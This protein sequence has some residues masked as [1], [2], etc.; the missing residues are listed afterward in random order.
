[1]SSL[2]IFATQSGN[3]PLSELDD[4]FAEVSQRVNTANYV[5]AGNQSNITNVGTLNSLSVFGNVVAGNVSTTRNISAGN[6]RTTG[7]ISAAGN[8][9]GNYLFG[10][11]GYLSNVTVS[12]NVAVT[13][14]ANGVSV[15]SIAGSGGAATVQIAG[16]ANVAVF[17]S[18]GVSVNGQISA[19]GNVDAANIFLSG[20]QVAVGN[21]TGG[22]LNATT[23]MS[24]NGNAT[25]G[26]VVV[27][28]Q[29][30]AA[31]NV[32]GANISTT[33]TVNATGNVRGANI[34]TDGVV[35]AVGNV[36]GANIITTGTV[37]AD[38]NVRGA[39]ISTDGVVTA[40]GNVRGANI[41]ANGT[42]SA[43]GNISGN[44]NILLP[45]GFLITPGGTIGNN[46]R[47]GGFLSAVGTATLGN[48]NTGGVIS[49]TGNIIADAG[50]FFIGNGSLLTGIAASSY[51]NSDVT[52]L[53]SN[54]GS[55]TVS[56]TGN[57]SGGY[58]FGNGSQLTGISTSSYGN[59]NVVANLAALSSNPVST[60]GNVTAGNFL[61]T[62]TLYS[63]EISTGNTT[64]GNLLATGTVSALGNIRTNG[65][66][67]AQGNVTGS[68][69]FGNGSQ[70]TGLAATY[71]NSNVVTLLSAFGSNSISTTGNVT[72]SAGTLSSLSTTGNV[73]ITGSGSRLVAA[74]IES[75]AWGY[76]SVELSGGTSPIP[77]T[78][79]TAKRVYAY[80]GTSGTASLP[81]VP[82]PPAAGLEYY[83]INKMSGVLTVQT[84]GGSTLATVPSGATCTATVT[85]LGWNI[86][87]GYNNDISVSGNVTGSYIFGNGSQLT[88]LPATYGNSNVTALLS[89]LGS[90]AISTTGNITGNYIVGNGS[91]LTG[92]DAPVTSVNGSTGAV[93]VQGLYDTRTEYYVLPSAIVHNPLPVGYFQSGYVGDGWTST[94]FDLIGMTV[95]NFA[96]VGS[97]GPGL[98]WT[99]S[100]TLE[101]S[102]A[103]FDTY[104]T[105]SQPS[106]GGYTPNSLRMVQ[107]SLDGPGQIGNY[108]I[109]EPNVAT[110]DSYTPGGT[111]QT[112]GTSSGQR[113]LFDP[114]P[115][116]VTGKANFAFTTSQL[117]VGSGLRVSP[118]A[119]PT[120]LYLKIWVSD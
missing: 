22:N 82:A 96:S 10:D 84:A 97:S 75:T 116:T 12:S 32:S 6:V 113:Y 49:A 66:I 43:A 90:N 51:G 112:A 60:T 44:L 25:V 46:I 118:A 74:G 53:L 72:A 26:N 38:G 83:L 108:W 102:Q 67:S 78:L 8:V 91:L 11:G 33:G 19:T 24:V 55:N 28:G 36:R 109:G 89:N 1:M 115:S 3:I 39:N 14:I 18:N 41:I 23:D 93:Q 105:P 94:G 86:A 76:T 99:V 104:V 95:T 58:I 92:I 30:T 15:I 88:G 17:Q 34:S 110:W 56:T 79:G 45:N 77:S 29:V 69:I 50:S 107:V 106:G 48:V 16:I 5:V 119:W 70:L 20:Q 31:G 101:F 100:F 13:Q 64:A 80:S 61:T 54:L 21:I 111:I 37:T 73:T 7:L 59:A 9:S 2:Y 117:A 40:G 63:N 42:V 57:V 4:N 27:T 85:A 114:S 35:T 62:G 52:A 120:Y 103:F 47:T 81:N 71:G 68:Y 98:Y 87:I 65:L